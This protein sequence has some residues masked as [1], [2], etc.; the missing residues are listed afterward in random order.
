MRPLYI[1][2][3]LVDQYIF[4]FFQAEDGIRDVAVT[5]VQTCAL[6]IFRAPTLDELYRSFRVGNV[7]TNANPDLGPEHLNGYEFGVNQQLTTRIFWRITLF[8]IGRAHV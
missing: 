3:E 2:H 6:P 7:V 4:F 8:E 5:G 1:C